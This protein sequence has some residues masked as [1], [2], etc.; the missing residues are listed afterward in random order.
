MTTIVAALFY[1]IIPGPA[2]LAALNLSV[3]VGQRACAIFLA[4]H[5]FGDLAWAFLAISAIIGVSQLGPS[6]F[7]IL[8]L[9]CGLYLVFLGYKAWQG[10]GAKAGVFIRKPWRAGLFLG[11][12]NPKAYPF[13]LAMFTAVFARFDDA[14]KFSNVI[15]L[16]LSAFTGFLVATV[17]VVVW[18]N[19]PL[20]RRLYLR[21]KAWMTKA[22]GLVFIVFGCQSIVKAIL[23][24]RSS[25]VD[26]Y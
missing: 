21:Y 7:D 2:T 24:I 4:C 17:F 15:P 26:H 25:M 16:V 8:G 23:S 13:A 19:L 5:L 20:T 22:T 12:T 1:V 9:V 18:T 10:N 14:M 11:F 6:L 3:T